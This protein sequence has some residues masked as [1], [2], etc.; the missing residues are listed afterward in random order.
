MAKK[1][2][3]ILP[4]N[5]SGYSQHAYD[6]LNLSNDNLKAKEILAF[7]DKAW[8]EYHTNPK[9]LKL[10]EDRF[11]LHARQNVEATTKIKLKRKLLGD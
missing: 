2:G 3:W 7:R 5:Y 4:K 9:Y 11:G 1:K 10:L 6:T 8:N